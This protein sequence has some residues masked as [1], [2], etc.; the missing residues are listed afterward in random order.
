ML[1]LFRIYFFSFVLIQSVFVYI[2]P[3]LP[4]WISHLLSRGIFLFP[5]YLLL[6]FL[7][8][9]CW[10]STLSV[11]AFL[12]ISLFNPYLLSLVYNNR[13]K[14]F[15]LSIWKNLFQ[16]RLVFS[17]AVKKST[18]NLVASPWQ[19]TFLLYLGISLAFS[20]PLVFCYFTSISWGLSFILFTF[21]DFIGC[22]QFRDFFL[23]LILEIVQ[24]L[25]L[26]ILSILSS[27]SSN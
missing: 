22:S 12:K 25:I 16:C 8:R 20:L 15:P 7:M 21:F 24:S 9:F 17:D 19:V 11:F 3:Q 2:Y 13:L 6:K 26:P 23:S 5:K 1:L 27:W 4:L 10:R 14:I 18:L